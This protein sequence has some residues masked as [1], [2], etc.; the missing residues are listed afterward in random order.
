VN[1]GALIL[2]ACK[3]RDFVRHASAICTAWRLPAS[4]PSCARSAWAFPWS[5]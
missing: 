3:Y 4:E 1:S 5:S 2:F